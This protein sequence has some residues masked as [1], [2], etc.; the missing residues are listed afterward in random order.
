MARA[1]K[2]L[3]FLSAKKDLQTSD[4]LS[5]SDQNPTA[6]D[7]DNAFFPFLCVSRPLAISLVFG[8]AFCYQ[9]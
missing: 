1:G 7:L 3:L 6:V 8:Q 4:P 2:A 5:I 9:G